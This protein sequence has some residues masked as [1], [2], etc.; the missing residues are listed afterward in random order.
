MLS[1]AAIAAAAVA[2]VPVHADEQ[3]IDTC[4]VEHDTDKTEID[5]LY[6]LIEERMRESGISAAMELFQKAYARSEDFSTTGC[7]RHAHKVGD[8]AYYQFYVP[9]RDLSSLELGGETGACGY[10]FFHGLM[11]HLIQEHPDP[12]FVTEVCDYLNAILR[13]VLGDI[14]PICY[15]GSGHGFM[16]R[17]VEDLP[18]EVWGDVARFVDAPLMQCASLTDATKR[19]R[20]ECEEG[21]YNVIV[22]WMET[23]QFG[24]VYDHDQPF[25][26][27]DMTPN[28]DHRRACY[29]EMAMKLDARSQNSPLRLVDMVSPV[30]DDE[31]RHMVFRVGIAGMVQPVASTERYWLLVSECAAVPGEYSSDCFENV[32]HGLFEHG[33]P[34]Q[35]YKKPLLV[36]A[37]EEAK[38][39]GITERCYRATSYRL[40]RFYDVETRRGI[41]DEYPAD[42]QELCRSIALPAL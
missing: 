13:D 7:H 6:G 21:V 16:L 8:M 15:H 11:E 37:S 12:A 41:C 33:A 17:H 19:E 5:C 28:R 36:C 14:R 42:R 39:A 31:L 26:V 32:I 18:V 38:R 2:L 40:S 4:V 1:G 35:E 10:G 3:A 22:D 24:F 30:V 23:E 9:T 20:E 25:R 34:A 27:C 29:Y